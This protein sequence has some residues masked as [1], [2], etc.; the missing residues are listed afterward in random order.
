M[1]IEELSLGVKAFVRPDEGANVGFIDTDKGWIVIDTTSS[2][3]EIQALLDAAGV[4]PEEICL[5][6]NTHYHADHTWGNQVFDCPILAHRLCRDRMKANLKGSWS[7]AGIAKMLDEY[8]ARDPTAA[9]E[10]RQK[11][12]DLS[13]TL[14]TEVIAG[15]RAL[16]LGNVRIELIHLDGHTPG[17]VIVWLPDATVLYAGDLLFIGR[18]P[19][20]SDAD[21]PSLIEA[22]KKLLG[23]K[24]TKI[25]PGH[26]PLC[27]VPEVVK[28]RNYLQST[29]GWTKDQ[30][31]KGR[32]IEEIASDRAA[33]RYVEEDQPRGRREENIRVMAEQ[34]AQ[35]IE[36]D[37][38][39][40]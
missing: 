14:P 7:P 35:I 31:K 11:L 15:H 1:R 32:S 26:G 5:V 6:I 23:F 28:L 30:L 24:A 37:V 38:Q 22:L 21:T 20:I 2:P 10:L 19:Y 25:V 33:P 27:G 4:K 39:M 3:A 9:T 13:I 40:G 34:I 29:W 8:E 12:T 17:S 18:Y 36:K 16:R